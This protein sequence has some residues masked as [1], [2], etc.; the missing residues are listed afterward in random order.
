MGN[1][2]EAMTGLSFGACMRYPGL[3]RVGL[4]ILR[5]AFA[6]AAKVGVKLEPLPGFPVTAFR[7]IIRSPLAVASLI[8][9]LTMGATDT[10]TSTL[11]SIRRGRP[12]EIDYLNGEIV[13]QG[14][15]VN[16]ATPYNAKVVELVREVEQT[17]QFYS[18]AQLESQFL[19]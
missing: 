1:S 11:Q 12:T 16:I 10:L 13:T 9:R 6:V 14:Q 19:F 2:L 15:K 5:E 7:F 8:L 18:P 3:R 4:F 17:G